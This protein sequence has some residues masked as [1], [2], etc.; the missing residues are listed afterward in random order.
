MK[1]RLIGQAND[2]GI[3]THFHHYTTA[4]KQINGIAEHVELIDFQS[5]EQL[6]TVVK[7]SQ[8][9]DI[10]I[11]FVGLNMNG[12]VKGINI[13]WG[14]FESTIIPKTLMGVY[15]N[16]L[17]WLPSDWGRKIAIENGINPEQI[18][19]APEGVDNNTFHPYLKPNK[20]RPFRFLLVGKYE[21][22]KSFDETIMAFAREFGNDPN[23]QLVIKSD[24]FKD[25]ELKRQELVNKIAALNVNNIKLIWGYKSIQ[26]I[27]NLYRSSDVFLFPTKAEGWGLPLIEAAACGLPLITT[28]YS[29]QTEFLQDIKSSCEFL[30]YDLEPIGCPEYQE[31]Y[32]TDDGNFGKW[33]VTTESAIA[34]AMRR[35]YTNYQ[36]FSTQALKNSE[37]IRS[38]YSWANS[39]IKSLEI[40]KKHGLL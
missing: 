19:V 32:P 38:K 40:L 33:A 30:P 14:V 23:I 4:I 22:R 7:E 29:G 8:P 27:A 2:S 9:N 10:N 18:E 37:I 39:A 31:F 28:Y 1:I 15:S 11:G 12:T 13:N 36:A 6:E 34:T 21:I 26:D 20:E 35:V 3:G 25:P 24:F 16:H 17:L 5:K